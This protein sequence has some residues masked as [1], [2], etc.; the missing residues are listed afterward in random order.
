MDRQQA[1]TLILGDFPGWKSCLCLV[2][3]VPLHSY[4]KLQFNLSGPGEILFL[5]SKDCFEPWRVVTSPFT[6]LHEPYVK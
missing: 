3:T 6:T 4:H 5:A 2:S 1:I